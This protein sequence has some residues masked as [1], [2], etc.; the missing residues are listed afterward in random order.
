VAQ[1][2]HLQQD[3]AATT[4]QRRSDRTNPANRHPNHDPPAN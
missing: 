1:R 4:G 3:S 2:G